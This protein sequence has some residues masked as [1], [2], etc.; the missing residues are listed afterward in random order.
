MG[1]R[2]WS[3]RKGLLHLLAVVEMMLHAANFLIV[4]MP[5]ACHEHHIAIACL[6]D[7]MTDS[8]STVFD[9]QRATHR[10]GII[11]YTGHHVGKDVGRNLKTRI[12]GCEHHAIAQSSGLGCHDGAFPLVAVAA[13]TYHGDDT[14]FLS[15]YLADSGDYVDHSIRR[16]GIVDDGGHFAVG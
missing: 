14:A 10:I 1:I 2:L 16:M 3:E 11:G 5:F 6:E 7:G 13:G 9:S 15:Y 8:F 4:F 12:V